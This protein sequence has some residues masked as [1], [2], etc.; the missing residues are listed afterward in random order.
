MSDTQRHIE[1]PQGDLSKEI[2][3]Q[4]QDG[5]IA[6]VSGDTGHKIDAIQNGLGVDIVDADKRIVS[7]TAPVDG[8]VSCFTTC[9]TLGQNGDNKVVN[10][11]AGEAIDVT[12]P[13]GPRLSYENYHG[14]V[15]FYPKGKD[16][17][18]SAPALQ[19]SVI[20]QH[21]DEETRDLLDDPRN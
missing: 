12:I 5:A 6:S 11:K 15:F 3:A 20:L 16:A 14:V 10:V 4:E 17:Q 19:K 8:E 13:E 18:N 2:E 9:D 7:I 1:Q 21:A